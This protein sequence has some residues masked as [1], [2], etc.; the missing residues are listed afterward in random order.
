MDNLGVRNVRFFYLGVG[1]V[2]D[3]IYDALF[4]TRRKKSPK[5]FFIFFYCLIYDALIYDREYGCPDF[6]RAPKK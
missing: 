4:M 3:P 5:I 2:N 1:G 6:W